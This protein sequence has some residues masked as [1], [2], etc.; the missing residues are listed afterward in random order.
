[1]DEENRKILD[2]DIVLLWRKL[3][4]KVDELKDHDTTV[5]LTLAGHP[6]VRERVPDPKCPLCEHIAEPHERRTKPQGKQGPPHICQ[7]CSVE[8]RP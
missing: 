3:S 2:R 4:A 6:A 1:M 7:E 5:L 8:F